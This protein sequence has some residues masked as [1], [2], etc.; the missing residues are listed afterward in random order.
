MRGVEMLAEWPRVIVLGFWAY[1]PASSYLLNWPIIPFSSVIRISPT[2]F[3]SCEA[4]RDDLFLCLR[5]YLSMTYVPA[6][7]LRSWVEDSF[8]YYRYVSEL[9]S[10]SSDPVGSFIFII[11]DYSVSLM[12]KGLGSYPCAVLMSVFCFF[13]PTWFM[14]FSWRGS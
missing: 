5:G 6:S 10:F 8:F 11:E 2:A 3:A 12:S 7:C 14:E 13:S 4:P 1:L 9:F